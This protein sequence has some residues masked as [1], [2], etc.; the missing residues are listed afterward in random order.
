MVFTAVCHYILCPCEMLRDS[1]E[2]TR[3][4]VGYAVTLPSYAQRERAHFSRSAAVL[5]ATLAHSTT[6]AGNPGFLCILHKNKRQKLRNFVQFCLNFCFFGSNHNI[7]W[8]EVGSHPKKAQHLVVSPNLRLGRNFAI[9]CVSTASHSKYPTS[10]AVL[11]SA[12]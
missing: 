7:L 11:P 3:F 6:Q 9:I 2:T 1:R 5:P 12:A 8:V 4:A 10:F